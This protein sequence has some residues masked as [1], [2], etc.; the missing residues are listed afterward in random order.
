MKFA[1]IRSEVFLNWSAF[2]NSECT[3]G[4]PQGNKLR[5]TLSLRKTSVKF[6]YL[7]PQTTSV[8]LHVTKCMSG[9][10][11]KH[12]HMYISRKGIDFQYFNILPA[13]LFYLQIEFLRVTQSNS[14]ST[15]TQLNK[16]K[17]NDRL[18][19]LFRNLQK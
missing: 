9:G 14:N 13:S 7:L 17:Q 10:K 2:W 19:H 5:F 4:P 12:R 3:S 15:L 1:G 6:S 11:N 16:T 18:S 8:R